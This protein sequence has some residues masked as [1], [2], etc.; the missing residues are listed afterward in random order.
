MVAGTVRFG[1]L[2][3]KS[4]LITGA[5]RGIGLAVAEKLAEDGYSLVLHAKQS[6]EACENLAERL[7]SNGTTCRVL[8]FDVAKREETRAAL[9]ADI[10]AHG[11]YYGVVS[12]AGVAADAPFPAMGAHMWDKVLRT[13]LDSF[14][15][16]IHPCVMPMIQS[17]QGGR[18][19]TIS[20]ISGVAGNRGQ[21]NYSAAK[22]GIIGATKALALEL[23]KRKITVNCV[24]PG[25][26]ETDMTA[27]L[28]MD[29]VQK[30]I[31]LRRAGRPEEVAAAVSFLMSDGAGYITR[32]V[33]NV[34]GGLV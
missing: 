3:E 6:R 15:N 1:T 9:E 32:Q 25:V 30:M 10:E 33:I 13:D 12:N 34:N 26:I 17:R 28:P 22:A 8:M 19:V 5:S 27:D 7:R 4:C 24:A 29:E 16:V 21:V 18:I 2:S 23:A 20:S 14:Y 31:P 11:A